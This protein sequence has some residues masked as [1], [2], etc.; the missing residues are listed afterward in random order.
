M[1]FCLSSDIVTFSFSSII[2]L[3]M[4]S[5]N[6]DEFKKNLHHVFLFHCDIVPTMN[7][8]KFFL[9]NLS[10]TLLS[11]VRVSLLCYI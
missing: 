11:R 4:V 3:F 1:F 9:F 10:S 6:I 5:F 8:A 2:E 7:F